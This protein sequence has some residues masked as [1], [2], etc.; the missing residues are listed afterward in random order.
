MSGLNG[1][2]EARW[3]YGSTARDYPVQFWIDPQIA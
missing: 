3:K 2:R 1:N